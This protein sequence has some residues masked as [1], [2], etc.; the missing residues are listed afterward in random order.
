MGFK[1]QFYMAPRV[2]GEPPWRRFPLEGDFRIWSFSAVSFAI[3]TFFAF[4]I[5][6]GLTAFAVVSFYFFSVAPGAGSCRGCGFVD[7]VF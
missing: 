5:G 1:S 3:T 7:S 4:G 6:F 2:R